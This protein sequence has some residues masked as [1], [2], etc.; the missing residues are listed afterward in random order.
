[1]T[2]LARTEPTKDGWATS[3]DSCVVYRTVLWYARPIQLGYN[4]EDLRGAP[5]DMSSWLDPLYDIART[6]SMTN[7]ADWPRVSCF[8]ASQVALYSWHI[9]SR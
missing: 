1:M 7:G 5:N 2:V 9:N 3:D 4:N 8:A 6:Y